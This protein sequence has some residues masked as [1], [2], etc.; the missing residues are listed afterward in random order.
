M[1][2]LAIAVLVAA[3]RIRGLGRHPVVTHQ[4]LI[5]RRV[6]LGVAVLV[7]GQR[8]A[9]GAMTLG[10]AAQ[11]PHGVLPTH[12]QA[13]E[14][15]R[16]AQGHVLPVRVRQH[17]VVQQVRKR[18][19]RD[20]HVQFVH[21][22]EVRRAEPAG[23]MHLAEKHF[24]GRPVL[25][26]P[27]PHPPFHRSPLPLPVAAGVLTLEPLDQSLGLQG[28]LALQQLLQ[29]RPDGGQWIRPRA[30][31]MRRGC[32]AGQLTQLA[33]LAGAFAIHVCLHR[34][35]LERCPFVEVPA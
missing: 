14:A 9:V 28:W 15:L 34:C 13:G 2:L 4:G 27:L 19:P 30:P 29:S 10:H 8:H 33:I 24:L 6:A 25:G 22:R 11:F 20:G 23:L 31:R 7:H 1:A 26:F 3:V 18:L 12:A 21:V 16:P 17:E 35:L 32:F 5:A